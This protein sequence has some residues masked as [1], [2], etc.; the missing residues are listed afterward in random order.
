MATPVQIHTHTSGEQ[1]LLV[2]AYLVETDHGVVAVDTT[3]LRGEA[4]AF[5]AEMEAIGKPLL[6]VLITHAHPDHVAGLAELVGDADV[7]IL[8]LPSVVAL[9]RAT[10]AAKHAQWGPVFG[11]EWIAEWAYPNQL[12]QDREAVTFDG[13]TYR[14]YDMGPGGDC[15]ANGLWIIE[16][17]PHVAFVGDLVFNGTHVYTADAYILSWLANLENA[18][19]LLAGVATLY[20]GHG[21]PG[22]LDVL[23]AHRAYLL[24][25]I[26]AVKDLAEGHPSLS[27]EAKEELVA[28]MNAIRPNA[29]LGFMIALGA[30]AVAAE[31]TGHSTHAATDTGNER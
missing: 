28:R 11:A 24:A 6:A 5:R 16:G 30:D 25:Y 13:V 18:R 31:L 29:G 7:P 1:G 15:D 8:A 21:G 20:P 2:N 27:A 12:V 3:L 26:A 23:D 19:T 9:M 4:R 22:T 10:E 17:E 14:I